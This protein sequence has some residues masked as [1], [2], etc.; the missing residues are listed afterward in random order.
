MQRINEIV[1]KPM[2]DWW[3]SLPIAEAPLIF[4]ITMGASFVWLDTP[5]LQSLANPVVEITARF[6]I[7]LLSGAYFVAISAGIRA[8]THVYLGMV[9]ASPQAMWELTRRT[10]ISLLPSAIWAWRRIMAMFALFL[11]QPCRL[12]R[13]V[14]DLSWLRFSTPNKI[15]YLLYPLSCCQLE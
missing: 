14:S 8:S 2:R 6:L 4:M 7:G 9:L 10:I 3:L 12:G 13:V 1:N 15:P 11:W 5:F